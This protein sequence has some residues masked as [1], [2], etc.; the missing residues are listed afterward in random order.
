MSPGKLG[1]AEEGSVQP[2]EA[3]RQRQA[4]PGACCHRRQ[5]PRVTISAFNNYKAFHT[6]DNILPAFFNDFEPG[7]VQNCDVSP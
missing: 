3:H 5:P 2:G 7:S 1:A 4:V 6:C